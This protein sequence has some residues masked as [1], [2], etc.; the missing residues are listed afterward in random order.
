MSFFNLRKRVD[1]AEV[2]PQNGSDDADATGVEA[3]NHLQNFEKLHK[4]DPNLPLDELNDVGAILASGN[5]EKGVEVEAT[6]LE[7]NSPY[8][9]VSEPQLVLPIDVSMLMRPT[10]GPRRREELRR[11]LAGQHSPCLGYRHASLHH[12]LRSEHAVFTEESGHIRHDLCHPTC[13]LPHWAWLGSD[14]P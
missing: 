2:T 14:L 6:L 11:R 9:E 4:L 5:V 13:C 8:P 3:L 10:T 12:W 7:E 1:H